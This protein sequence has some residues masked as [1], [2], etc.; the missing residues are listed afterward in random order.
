MVMTKQRS[1]A[2][3]VWVPSW[4]FWSTSWPLPIKII[5]HT[6]LHPPPMCVC[7][8]VSSYYML[9]EMRRQTLIYDIL[10]TYLLTSQQDVDSLSSVAYRTPF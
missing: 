1:P 4:P 3:W 9:Q 5:L 6:P 7:L 2:F 8:S 10:L